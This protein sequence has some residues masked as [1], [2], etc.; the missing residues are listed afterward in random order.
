M[1]RIAT[2]GVVAAIGTLVFVGL[3]QLLGGLVG[4][5]DEVWGCAV[6]AFFSA[7]WFQNP[8]ALTMDE[9]VRP[10]CRI[11]ISTFVAISIGHAV[12]QVVQRRVAVDFEPIGLFIWA[13]LAASWWLIPGTM[14][15]LL[16][17]NRLCSRVGP[18]MALQPTRA[19]K[20]K[21]QRDRRVAARAAER[22]R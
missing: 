3:G 16:L 6:G 8:S 20:P 2:A 13:M 7:L 5:R 15:V 11:V 19:A 21:K 22:S 18:N 12:E 10:A 17:S 1:R 9:N 4:S 14:L